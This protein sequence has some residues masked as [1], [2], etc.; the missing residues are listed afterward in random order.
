ML[1]GLFFEEIPTYADIL[2]GTPKL[3]SLFK[4]SKE[5]KLDERQLVTLR[6]IEPRFRP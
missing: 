5:F 4:L 3:T 6:G 1:L 2:N